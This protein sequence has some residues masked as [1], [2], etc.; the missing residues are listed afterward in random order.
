MLFP[1]LSRT[2]IESY[3]C[4]FDVRNSNSQNLGDRH[5]PSAGD[6]AYINFGGQQDG[7]TTMG[8]GTQQKAKPKTI[9]E[10]LHDRITAFVSQPK[11]DEEHD[12]G[13]EFAKLKIEND[14]VNTFFDEIHKMSDTF[15]Y[16]FI[17][18]LKL[19]VSTLQDHA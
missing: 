3:L 1:L 14:M 11:A 16:N 18:T 12:Y 13:A 8:A 5:S 9:T 7:F 10:V 6:V 17:E 2:C 19:D 15:V 4:Y